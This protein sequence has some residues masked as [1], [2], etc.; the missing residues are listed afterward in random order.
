MNSLGERVRKLRNQK[1]MEL[2][3]LAAQAK[4]SVGFLADIES[5]RSN[6]SIKTLKKLA[7][8]LDTSPD[9][10][11][12]GKNGS[13]IPWYEKDT[14]PTMEDL[15]DIIRFHPEL[16]LFGDK[17]DESKREDLLRILRATWDFSKKK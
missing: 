16:R 11:L 15:E 5:G 7:E 9:Y 13:S 12:L 6:P 10:L 14:P 1:G 4:I 17:L 2:K 8:A 3:E